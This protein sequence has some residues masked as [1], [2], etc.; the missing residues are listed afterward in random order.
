MPFSCPFFSLYGSAVP[1]PAMEAP[2]RVE[3]EAAEAVELSARPLLL[4]F[5]VDKLLPV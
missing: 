3:T 5:L 2:P 4:M 1:A